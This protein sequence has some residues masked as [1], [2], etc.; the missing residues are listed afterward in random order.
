M[1]EITDER[2]W[3]DIHCGALEL[4][5]SSSAVRYRSSVS[6]T[7]LPLFVRH[8]S[9][10]EIGEKFARKLGWELLVGL[11]K[12]LA[13][14]PRGLPLVGRNQTGCEISQGLHQD[15]GEEWHSSFV[16]RARAQQ[17]AAGSLRSSAKCLRQC[18]GTH[19]PLLDQTD[20]LK[21]GGS[22]RVLRRTKRH[23]G[24]VGRM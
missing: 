15:Q 4:Q 17:F 12:P 13:T 24:R 6:R 5:Q 11:C 7:H 9:L 14:Q 8:R 20:C 19:L 1:H 2:A 16:T 3:R 10:A 18:S 22:S 21:G 23:A